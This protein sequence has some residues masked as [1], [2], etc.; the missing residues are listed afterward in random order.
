MGNKINSILEMKNLGLPVPKCVFIMENDDVDS[1]VEEYFSLFPNNDY[2]TIRTDT[3]DSAHSCKR[4]LT[5]TRTEIKYL[6]HDWKEEFQI[7]L[8]EF[9][10]EKQEI[11]SGNMW[12]QNKDIIIEGANDHHINFANGKSLDINVSVNRFY[13]FEFRF[14]RFFIDQKCFSH[15]ELMRLVR[16]ARKV[17]YTNAI[18]EFSFFNDEKLYFWEIKH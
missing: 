16:L 14:H 8:Q 15:S 5:A 18:L 11:K 6:S 2:Y 3:K 4:L 10:D 13:S 7:I 12:L 9:I 17:P 1:K